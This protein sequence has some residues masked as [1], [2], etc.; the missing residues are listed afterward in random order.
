MG[1]CLLNFQNG[2]FSSLSKLTKCSIQHR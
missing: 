2:L 1:Y